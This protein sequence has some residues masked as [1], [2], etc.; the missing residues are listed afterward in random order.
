AYEARLR[1]FVSDKQNSA[2]RLRGFFAPQTAIALAL[3]NLAVNVMSVPF[4]G[5]RLTSRSLRD[6]LELPDYEVNGVTDGSMNP[7]PS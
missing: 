6:R 1:S 7:L 5:K 2:L 3:R 4:V